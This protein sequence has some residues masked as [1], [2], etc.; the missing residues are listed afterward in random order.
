M[1][2]RKESLR[3]LRKLCTFSPDAVLREVCSRVSPA[4]QQ[5]SA[6]FAT[7]LTEVVLSSLSTTEVCTNIHMY[8]HTARQSTCLSSLCVCILVHSIPIGRGYVYCDT[9]NIF[10]PCFYS[11]CLHACFPVFL[12]VSC[13]LSVFLSVCLSVCLYILFVPLCVC[14]SVCL[15]VSPPGQH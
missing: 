15:S 7:Q 14:L 11:F 1:S 9:L 13:F 3:L 2:C 4:E 6:P 5:Q 10:L 12:C 8:V